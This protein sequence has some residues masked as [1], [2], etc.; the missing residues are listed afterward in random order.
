MKKIICCVLVVAVLVLALASCGKTKM[1]VDGMNF[2]FSYAHKSTE[3]V[4]CSAQYAERFE[5]TEFTEYSLAAQD[6]KL[7]FAGASSESVGTYEIATIGKDYVIYNVVIGEYKG[8]AA[9][10]DG[11][12][13]FTLGEYT[14]LFEN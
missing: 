12:L 7:T 8:V 14:V 9:L 10:T 11:S 5:K 4:A 2:T 6:G 13:L 3:V 1:R